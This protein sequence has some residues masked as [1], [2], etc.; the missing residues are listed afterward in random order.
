[1]WKE[2]NVYPPPGMLTSARSTSRGN[3]ANFPKEHSARTEMG[4]NFPDRQ[5]GS[6]RYKFLKRQ[7]RQV[8]EVEEE[9]EGEEATE[10]Q[11]PIKRPPPT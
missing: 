8:E 2:K 5:N 7:T 1:M 11:P 6:L 3:E 4:A 9:E 10:D